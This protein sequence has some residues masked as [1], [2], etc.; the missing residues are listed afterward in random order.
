[1]IFFCSILVSLASLSE[2]NSYT[3]LAKPSAETVEKHFQTPTGFE[4]LP[5]VAPSFAHWLRNLPLKPEGSPV[6]LFNGRPKPLQTVHAAVIDID[7][8]KK[9][10]QQ[11]ADAVIRLRAEYQYSNQRQDGICFRFTSGDK[12]SWKSWSDGVRPSIK[13]NKVTWAR[14]AT[15]D[16]SYENFQKYLENIFIWAGTASLEKELSAVP[17]GKSL[18]I[19]DVFIK[20]GFPGH[21]VIIV[22]AAENKEGERIFLLA[23]SYMPAQS[24]HVLKNPKN[25]MSPWYSSLELDPLVT[26]EW[27]F[28]KGTL[29][30]FTEKGCP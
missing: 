23:Q 17:S 2:A 5:S 26:P 30:R 25:S 7:V 27:T 21:A 1:M 28:P 29:K 20:G 16:S 4:R 14:S 10:L 9:D 8:S 18:E 3:W 19:G 15:K 24:I 12:S 6:L 22:D 11:C 13:G